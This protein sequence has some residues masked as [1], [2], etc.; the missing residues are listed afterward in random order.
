MSKISIA[1]IVLIIFSACSK[2][3]Q[4]HQKSDEENPTI[5]IYY[6]SAN[7]VYQ[8]GQ[9][10]CFRAQLEDNNNLNRVVV[11]IKDKNSN[12]LKQYE[13]FPG[14]KIFVVDQKYSI[15]E[16]IT[17]A[18]RLEFEANDNNGNSVKITLPLSAKF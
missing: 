4:T 17:E 11:S 5:K 18:F 16:N 8:P 3:G 7:E 9:Q 14:C 6:P 15:P 13:F 12:P 1:V 2:S 10:L